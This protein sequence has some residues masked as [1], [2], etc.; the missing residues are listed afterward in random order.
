MFRRRSTEKTPEP[1]SPADDTPQQTAVIFT[2]A[3]DRL[4]DMTVA[5]GPCVAAVEGRDPLVSLHQQQGPERPDQMAALYTALTGDASTD[6]LL[7]V[8]EER[9]SRLYRCSDPFVDAMADANELLN[10]LGDEDE[11][12]GDE[13]YSSQQAK[14]AELD[15][16][17][18]TAADWHSAMVSTRNRL[19]RMGWARVARES[20]QPLYCWYGPRL[21]EYT[22][23][24]GRGPYPPEG[25]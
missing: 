23:V 10:R 18:M 24:H 16:A 4:A 1:P 15:A 6:V 17:W 9:G 14:F 2:V 11:A 12:R 20:G 19:I 25:A 5:M 8:A 21:R 13:S 7:L 22:V 3:E